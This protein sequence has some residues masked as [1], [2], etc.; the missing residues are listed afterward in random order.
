MTRSRYRR[1]SRPGSLSN[2]SVVEK[3][4]MVAV[5]ARAF[6]SLSLDWASAAWTILVGLLIGSLLVF[7][8]VI[9][10]GCY[11]LLGLLACGQ[12]TIERADGRSGSA[13]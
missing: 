5:S 2:P 4:V 6:A 1:Q 8:R 10:C 9:L 11:R 7:F 3:L 13:V 12:H